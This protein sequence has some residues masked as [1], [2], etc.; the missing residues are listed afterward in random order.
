MKESERKPKQKKSQKQGQR[1]KQMKGSMVIEM[2]YIM[3]V[4][5]LMFVCIV[6]AAFYFHDKC[7]LKGAAY[8][9]AVLGTQK[10]RLPGGLDMGELEEHFR[11]RTRGKLILF[12]GADAAVTETTA[13]VEVSVTAVRRK[14]KLSIEEKAFITDPEKKI[15][16]VQKV[17]Q[18]LGG[19]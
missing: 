3:G 8:E 7:I 19:E 1:R 11:Q 15:R 5:F 6:Q 18:G 13:F 4:F 9:T 2:I 17:K 10:Q 14:Q 16:L 12:A